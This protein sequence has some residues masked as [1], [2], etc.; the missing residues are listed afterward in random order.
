MIIRNETA[1]RA[2]IDYNGAK[3]YAERTAIGWTITADG[4]N[5]T[6]VHADK[7]QAIAALVRLVN[8]PWTY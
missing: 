1:K 7:W 5:V 2:R 3:W 6:K 8:K 4:F